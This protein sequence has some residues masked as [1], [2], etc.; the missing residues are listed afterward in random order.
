ML[1]RFLKPFQKYTTWVFFCCFY[2]FSDLFLFPMYAYFACI[3]VQVPHAW[4]VS[5]ESKKKKAWFGI[6]GSGEPP[7]SCWKLNCPLEQ[8]MFLN[9]EPSLQP[10]YTAS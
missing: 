10:K 6:T 5:E 4:E 7:C 9:T 3:Y 2:P 8:Q 1:F